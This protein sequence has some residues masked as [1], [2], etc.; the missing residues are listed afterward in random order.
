MGD[1]ACRVGYTAGPMSKDFPSSAATRNPVGSGRDVYR[2]GDSDKQNPNRR[3]ETNDHLGTRASKIRAFRSRYAEVMRKTHMK[4]DINR[5]TLAWLSSLNLNDAEHIRNAEL[6]IKGDGTGGSSYANGE[7]MIASAEKLFEKFKGYMERAKP[8]ISEQSAKRWWKRYEDPAV[9]F[10]AKEYWINHQFEGFIAAWRQACDERETLLKNP[11]FALVKDREEGKMIADKNK[12]L[13]MHYD[14]RVHLL[15]KARAYILAHEK[16]NSDLYGTA[17]GMLYKA[18]SKKV[19]AEHKVGTWLERIFKTNASREKIEKFLSF[20][21]SNSLPVLIGKWTEVKQRYDTINEKIKQRGRSNVRGWYE[22]GESQFLSMHYAQRLRYVEEAEHRLN[23]ANNIRDEIPIFIEIRHALDI[24]DW[25]EAEEKIN[26]AQGLMALSP[27]NR[28]RLRSMRQY[29]T[30]FRTDGKKTAE[31]SAAERIASAQKQI[32]SILPLLPQS[33]RALVLRGLKGPHPNRYIHQLRWTVYNNKWCRDKGYLTHKRANQFANE[34]SQEQTHKAGKE[35]GDTGMHDVLNNK[36]DSKKFIRKEE[37]AKHKPTYRHVDISSGAVISTM[38][39][40]LEH[41][42]HPR[43]LYWTTFC[44]NDGESA[45]S[46][47]WHNDL[48]RNLSTLRSAT[49]ALESAGGTY[50]HRE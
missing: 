13:D 43:V 14:K 3:G 15:S 1:N 4:Y 28:D 20:D 40:W 44:A 25:E 35:G 5:N 49:R 8:Y 23:D 24:R 31:G 11:A 12:F 32:D 38:G 46:E 2:A 6:F 10:K 34:Q 50:H 30:Q 48:F 47:S 22:V 29:L 9:G 7:M 27:E 41:E 37:V 33:M 19:L 39:E 36:N 17:K 42:Q 45:M 16:G 26:K 21:G 18:V